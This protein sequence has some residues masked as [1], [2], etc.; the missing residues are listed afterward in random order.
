MAA[1]EELDLLLLDLGLPGIEGHEVIERLP[2]VV[3]APSNRYL[4]PR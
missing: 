2:G 4:G 1:E 3:R